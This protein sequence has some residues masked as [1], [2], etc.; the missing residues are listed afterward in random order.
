MTDGQAN[1]DN[2]PSN[3]DIIAKAGFYIY[4]IGFEDSNRFKKL[5]CLKKVEGTF[6]SY[7]IFL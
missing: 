1:S 7:Q 6:Q 3:C 5:E 2:L 4:I